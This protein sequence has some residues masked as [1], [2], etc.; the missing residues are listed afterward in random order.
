MWK[1]FTKRTPIRLFI[2][3][4]IIVVLAE[5][6]LFNAK[7]FTRRD[8][9]RELSLSDAVLSGFE[10]DV[11]SGALVSVEANPGI[12]FA[13]VGSPVSTLY[14]NVDP[15]D[16]DSQLRVSIDFSDITNAAYRSGLAQLTIIRDMSQSRYAACHFSGEVGSL[17]LRF[18][19]QEG[20]TITLYEVSINKR[21][22]LNLS[23]FR[24][25]LIIG[26]VTA[27]Y[28]LVR[29]P[30][31]R[32]EYDAGRNMHSRIVICTTAVFVFAALGLTLAYNHDRSQ[33]IVSD[34]KSDQ[35]N[36]ITKDLVDAF[37][38]GQVSLIE[39][40]H[41]ELTE[42]DNPYD[43]SERIRLGIGYKWDHLLFNNKYYSYYGIAPVV[44]LFLP[45]HVAT[46][47]YFP[48]VWAVF[49]FGAL[50]IVFLTKLYM[51]FIKRWFSSLPFGMV[52]MGLIILQTASGVWVN[53]SS[54]LFYEI[55]QTG[56]F[57]FTVIGSWALL[58]AT[59]CKQPRSAWLYIFAG[60]AALSLAVMCRPTT[61]VYAVIALVF[62]W[63]ERNTF[64]AHMTVPSYI[65][66]FAI[67]FAVLGGTQALYNY[68]RFGSFFEFGIK[69]SL[70]INDFTNAQYHPRMALIGFYNFL[71]AFPQVKP[72]FPF[73]F[74]QF[75]TLNV[76]G[77]YFIANFIAIGIFFRA[78]PAFYLFRAGSTS[79]L[80]PDSS[81]PLRNMR[82]V[83]A[84]LCIAAPIIIIFSIWESGYGY[85]YCADFSWQIII[86]ALTILY[87]R[88]LH[89]KDTDEPRRT[90]NKMIVF[91]AAAVAVNAAISLEYMRGNL[92]GDALTG[93]LRFARIFQF[94]A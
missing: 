57:M 48:T 31:F 91:T 2:L 53:F 49:L 87:I 23:V 64:K 38:A 41:P 28:A 84:L 19:V 46:G 69:Y 50:G 32:D 94:W 8:Q 21:I 11:S 86:G 54:P 71:A 93:F 74:S 34:F 81:T 6:F 3:L 55:A 24:I 25:L 58:S 4:C 47:Y 75:S 60:A 29:V 77:Y 67:P 14:L 82:I 39:T 17:R 51:A 92:R 13:A 59:L 62:L 45:Y 61:A 88:F 89:Q 16:S 80:L 72:E 56:A 63:I 85:R 36:Q 43:W 35:G 15:P 90:Y 27:I 76:N 5:F 83:W 7:T 37:L 78:L 79:R 65:C 10:Y 52:V 20:K 12:E 73:I 70:T 42:M 30:L 44:L 68:A 26:V 33:G 9:I 1:A 40:P 66:A 18:D 22:P